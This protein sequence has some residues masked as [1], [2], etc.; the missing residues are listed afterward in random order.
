M[1]IG[2]NVSSENV[3]SLNYNYEDGA[4]TNSNVYYSRRS[5]GLVEVVGYFDAIRVRHTF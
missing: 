1:G 3:K 5:S 4:G 2:N